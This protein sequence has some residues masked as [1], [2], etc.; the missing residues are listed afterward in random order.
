MLAH[1]VSCSTAAPWEPRPPLEQAV[2]LCDAATGIRNEP[3]ESWAS[4]LPTLSFPRK[5]AAAREA[6]PSANFDGPRQRRSDTPP[7]ASIADSRCRES[8]FRQPPI[9]FRRPP[10]R[11]VVDY[12]TTRVAFRADRVGPDNQSLQTDVSS[13]VAG[14]AR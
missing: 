4:R 6:L 5:T 12:S 3:V 2:G 8:I 10:I 9:T 1:D 13:R 14:R 11:L 7:A